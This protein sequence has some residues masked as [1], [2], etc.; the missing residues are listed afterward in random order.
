MKTKALTNKQM[1]ELEANVKGPM[2]V[3]NPM[4]KQQEKELV[5]WTAKH[6]A[7]TKAKPSKTK[8]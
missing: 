2:M 6:K 4:T 7:V 5:E 3:Y 8:A 1:N